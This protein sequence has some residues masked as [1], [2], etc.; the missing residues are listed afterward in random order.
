MFPGESPEQIGRRAGDTFGSP[1]EA[2]V[3]VKAVTLAVTLALTLRVGL[4]YRF[5][6][7]LAVADF[8]SNKGAFHV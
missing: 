5:P 7:Y 4:V 8:R 1:S 3:R 6:K 2:D